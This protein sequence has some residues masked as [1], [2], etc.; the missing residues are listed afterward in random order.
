MLTVE[1][2]RPGHVEE[3]QEIVRLC[4]L[5]LQSRF[6]LS[7]WVPAPPVELM[8]RHAVEK[9]VYA[10]RDGGEAVATFT[11]GLSGWPEE[12]LPFWTNAY[13]RAAYLSRLAVLPSRQ[14]EGIGRWCMAQV[15]RLAYEQHCHV[16]RLDA[17]RD[18]APPLL[19]YRQLGFKDRGVVL[20][21]NW[22]GILQELLLLERLL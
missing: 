11:F 14:K 1:R 16:I 17:I 5:D 21:A 9:D 13:H 20:W 19:M 22:Y 15:D 12:S 8:R 2:V 18:F 7:H 4:G 6:G 10:V 3:M